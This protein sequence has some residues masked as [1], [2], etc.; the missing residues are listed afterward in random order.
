MSGAHQIGLG[1][2]KNNYW[3]KKGPEKWMQMGKRGGGG[4]VNVDSRGPDGKQDSNAKISKRYPL[5]LKMM[6]VCVRTCACAY[7][8]NMCTSSRSWFRAFWSQTLWPL[9]PDKRQKSIL[10]RSFTPIAIFICI[11]SCHIKEGLP[12]FFLLTFLLF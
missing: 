4:G 1:E 2:G 8:C 9:E 10:D 12:F 6:S 7:V 5:F 11:M 3:K